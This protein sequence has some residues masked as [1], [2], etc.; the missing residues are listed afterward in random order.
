VAALPAGLLQRGDG[1]F[2]GYFRPDRVSMALV[3]LCC[4]VWWAT[5][6]EVEVVPS[7]AVAVLLPLTLLPTFRSSRPRDS[8]HSEGED[9]SKTV[10][11]RACGQ[12]VGWSTLDHLGWCCWGREKSFSAH[13]TPTQ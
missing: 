4:H 1:D 12:R 10:V 5:A 8:D 9:G 11:A 3:C 13:P 6:K 7:H 2:A